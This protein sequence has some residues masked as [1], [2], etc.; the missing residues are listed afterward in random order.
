[1]KNESIYSFCY[2]QQKKYTQT[3][4]PKTIV[5]IQVGKFYEAYATSTEGYPHLAELGPLLD[6]QY[7][8]RDNSSNAKK[9]LKP[10]QFGIHC[11]TISKKM[12]ILIEN[13]YTV[14]LFDQKKTSG[15]VIIRECAGVFTKGTRLSDKEQIDSSYLFSIYVSEEKQL[16][17]S[18]ALLAIGLSMIDV[19]TGKTICH[20]FYSNKLDKNFGLDELSRML[21]TFNPVE[22]VIYFEPI[23]FDLV[24]LQSIRSYLE[25]DKYTQCYLYVK[26]NDPI[27]PIPPCSVDPLNLLT[28]EVKTIFYQNTF[29]SEIFSLNQQKSPLETLSLTKKP[30]ATISIILLIKYIA[31]HNVLLL[32]NILH[33]EIYIYN[34]HL[35]L[36][37]SAIEQLNII[38]SNNLS[39][40]CKLQSLFDVINRTS[41]PMGRRFLKENLFNPLS[42]QN[43]K[44]ILRRYNFIEELIEKNIFTQLKT[45]LKNIFDVERLHRRMAIGTIAPYEFYRLDTYYKSTNK[46]L[47]ILKNTS[48][49]ELFP[50]DTQKNFLSFQ[51]SYEKIFDFDIMQNHNNYNEIKK[52][53]LK[54]RTSKTIDK[55]QGKINSNES[56]IEAVRL[57]LNRMI[58]SKENYVQTEHTDKLSYF[59]TTNKTNE[60][61]II[62]KLKKLNTIRIE[63]EDKTI[64]FDKN[65]IKYPKQG[66]PRITVEAISPYAT[67]L[68]KLYSELREKIKIIFIDHILQIYEKNKYLMHEI[69]N[70]IKMI[71][72]LV[73]GAIVANE[74]FYSKPII[75]SI[76]NIPSYI[77]VEEMRH[78]IVERLNKQTEFIPNDMIL[79]NVPDM[80]IKPNGMIL[81]GLNSAGKSVSMKSIGITV[82]LAQIGYFV[83]AKRFEYEPYMAIYARITGNDNILKGLSSFGLEMTELDSILIRTENLGES[84]LIIGDEVCRGTEIISAKSLVASAIISLAECNSTFIFSS[85]LHDIPDIDEIKNLKNL[86]ICHL[87][88]EFDK[89]KD[90]VIFDRKIRPGS[91]PSVY[92]MDVARNLIKN[93]TFINRAE[94]IKQRL[95]GELQV[96]PKIKNSSYNKDLAVKQCAICTYK[97]AKS[98]DKEL[99]THHI[100]FQKDCL[101][102]GKIKNKEYLTKNELYNLVVLCRQCHEKVHRGVINIKSYMHTTIGPILNWVSN[103]MKDLVDDMSKLEQMEKNRSILIKYLIK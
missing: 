47:S 82:V 102:N 57:Y 95:M 10:N 30:H 13:N 78:A 43:K 64:E 14:V 19:S 53:F 63:L 52:S 48:L 36:G 39:S 83:P 67:E 32:K 6:I 62:E 42:Q 79:G 17:Q 23:K 21:Q 85:H 84:T 20:E 50:K 16:H 41:T 7:I 2:E 74:Y 24:I 91:G 4:G 77:R 37:N 56:A 103:P 49:S 94:I 80:E 45:E 73:S 72:F 8:R 40:D 90:C 92:G 98:T 18:P 66:K 44:L 68:F 35:I 65:E 55:I 26:S 51:S 15:T 69:C 12:D 101:I 88:S 5:F 75:P 34:R 1:M 38:D 33:P 11:A 71:D 100:N 9:R 89:E 61:I 46:I 87:K 86:K 54:P 97:P 28:P 60:K 96:I 3:H 25:L 93:T 27:D 31:S 81:F 22:I 58:S 99:D 70:F 76:D 59:Y 29:L